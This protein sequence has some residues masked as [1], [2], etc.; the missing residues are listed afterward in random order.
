MDE[1][2]ND[3]SVSNVTESVNEPPSKKVCLDKLE[4]HDVDETDIRETSLEDIEK[5]LKEED[6]LL[7]EDDKDEIK[8]DV[9]TLIDVKSVN[10]LLKGLDD[11]YQ[12][13]EINNEFEGI[14]SSIQ[15]EESSTININNKN[16]NGDDVEKKSE[17]TLE[18]SILKAGELTREESNELLLELCESPTTVQD[19]QLS[20]DTGSNQEDSNE[21]E[22]SESDKNKEEE[23]QDEPTVTEKLSDNNINLDNLSSSQLSALKTDDNEQKET[24]ESDKSGQNEAQSANESDNFKVPES[25]K[26]HDE[27]MEVDD[28]SSECVTESEEGVTESESDC[29]TKSESRETISSSEETAETFDS[30]SQEQQQQEKD[31]QTP[32]KKQ[33]MVKLNFMRKFASSFG[34]L[35]RSD[36]EEL[37]LEKITESIVFRSESTDL[38]TKC[39]KQDEIIENLKQRIQSITKQYND[40]DMIHK[41]IVKDLKEKPD[42]PITPVK[43]T[44]AVGLQ[45]YQPH[46]NS[47]NINNLKPKVTS[48]TTVANKPTVKR[49]N[50]S[51]DINEKEAEAKRKKSNKIITPMRPPL[52]E[53]EK[54]SLEKQE[55]TIEQKIRTKV[56]KSDAASLPSSTKPTS[57]G[58]IK[59]QR[60]SISIA[61]VSKP[62]NFK[63]IILLFSYK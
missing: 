47:N 46:N 20:N 38:R 29:V 60:Y 23:M 7:K 61:F 36:L 19:E 30:S 8:N 56:I 51:S 33:V 14:L 35:S 13:S 53:K 57:N 42:Q 63:I 39:E 4:G 27:K 43:I 44:R 28:S 18:K 59:I 12:N 31:E 41:R 9:E 62:S 5:L 50:E 2:I 45:V 16:K 55:A 22:S 58:M 15:N 37:L 24:I 48:T 17:E 26:L 3:E 25:K 52:S 11:D 40:L 1:A 54:A 32:I 34:K 6:T 10:E 21:E 49:P